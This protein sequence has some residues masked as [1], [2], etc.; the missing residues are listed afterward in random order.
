MSPSQPV[1]VVLPP[2]VPE[3]ERI[4]AITLGCL[5][6]VRTPWNVVEVATPDPTVLRLWL[7]GDAHDPTSTF[8]C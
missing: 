1:E 5:E 3:R 2:D 4:L 8:S 6:R 7:L